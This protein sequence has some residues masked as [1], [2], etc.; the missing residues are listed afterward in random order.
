[1]L[2]RF[3]KQLFTD[4]SQNDLKMSKYFKIRDMHTI[5]MTN[6]FSLSFI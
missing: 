5:K 3:L 4:K 2:R 1:M 6:F